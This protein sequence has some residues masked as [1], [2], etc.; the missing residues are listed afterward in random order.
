MLLSRII[1]LRT[2]YSSNA[3]GRGMRPA[4]DVLA[5]FG[6][7]NTYVSVRRA[8]ETATNRSGLWTWVPCWRDLTRSLLRTL[9]F[10]YDTENA[11][12]VRYTAQAVSLHASTYPA[13][14]EA[15]KRRGQTNDGAGDC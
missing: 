10:V 2:E 15:D 12:H 8:G 1:K 3:S 9:L 5:V 7:V 13:G 6:A 4:C 11:G 14:A